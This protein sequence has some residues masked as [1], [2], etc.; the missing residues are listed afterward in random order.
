MRL[1]VHPL[2]FDAREPGEAEHLK[3]TRSGEH[4][5]RPVHE[6]VEPAG[7]GDE[8]VA[9]PQVEVVGVGEDDSGV[10]LEEVLL[11]EGFYRRPGAH[12]HEDRGFN[13]AV[14][15]LQQP[16][17]CAGRGVFSDYVK[18]EVVHGQRTSSETGT[19]R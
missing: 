10:E 15:R 4:R 5:P 13:G 6:S 3:A 18:A 7:A 12:G 16:G 17:P 1:E 14:R 2:L 11:V 19:K 8:L 9:R